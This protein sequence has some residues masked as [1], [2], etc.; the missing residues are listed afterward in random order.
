MAK[1]V[2]LTRATLM[3]R[4]CA[5]SSSWRTRRRVR[6]KRPRT[7][8]AKVTT[9]M[10]SMTTERAYQVLR[11]IGTGNSSTRPEAPPVIDGK[12]RDALDDESEAERADGEVDA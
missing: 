6:R 1:T 4:T 3:P 9:P 8:R 11:V 12:A 2:A 10:T 7:S 5:A